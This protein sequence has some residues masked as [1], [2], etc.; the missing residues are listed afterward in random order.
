MKKILKVTTAVVILISSLMQ[1]AFAQTIDE[2]RMRRDI[3]IAENVLATLIKQELGQEKTFFGFDV[4]GSYQP[5]YGIT[6]RVPSDHAIPM[7]LKITGAD[8]HAAPVI[9]DDNGFQ[10]SY[11]TNGVEQ[12]EATG[13]DAIKLKDKIKEKKRVSADS[14]KAVFNQRIIDAASTFIVDYGDLLSQLVPTERIIVTNQSDRAHFY[15]SSGKRTRIS[16][17]GLRSDITAFRQGRLSREEALKKLVVVSTE[18]IETKEPDMEMLSS[19]FSR[20]YRPDLSKTYF[21]EGNVYYERLKDFG[22]I[23]YFRVVSSEE[24]APNRFTLPTIGAENLD[25]AARDKKVIEL[26]PEFEQDMKQNMVEYG[27][28]VKSLKDNESLIFNIAMTK[29]AGCGIPSTLELAI[30]AS[31]L[32]DFAA[33]KIDK[34]AAISKIAVKKGASQ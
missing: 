3:E 23:F 4:N 24:S 28:T 10:F 19:I 17:E 32:K 18:S 30:K 11:R 7:V 15:F 5:G 25:K 14:L 29:C 22:A 34:N 13:D 2:E 12:G 27:R 8:V 1:H 6:F 9:V 26:Y 31:V 20:L 21:V 33:G 16:V